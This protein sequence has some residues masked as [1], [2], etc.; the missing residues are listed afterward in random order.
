V[1]CGPHALN[2]SPYFYGVGWTLNFVTVQLIIAWLCTEVRRNRPQLTPL[3]H[4]LMTYR[5]VFVLTGLF[6]ISGAC[7]GPDERVPA[8]AERGILKDQQEARCWR[9]RFHLTSLTPSFLEDLGRLH[10]P[11]AHHDPG[12]TSPTDL[13]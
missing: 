5:D 3:S 12:A 6:A 11:W 1:G 7:P 8:A 4:D 9:I 13:F 2:A 10:H